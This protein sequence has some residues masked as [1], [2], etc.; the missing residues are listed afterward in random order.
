M[1]FSCQSAQKPPSFIYA[2][3]SLD[4]KVKIFSAILDVHKIIGKKNNICGISLQIPVH[5]QLREISTALPKTKKIGLLFNQKKQSAIFYRCSC[6][7]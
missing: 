3:K 7:K 5:I 6:F 4:N 1:I 2:I